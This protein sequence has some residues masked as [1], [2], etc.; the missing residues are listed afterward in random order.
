MIFVPQKRKCL[1][2]SG[3]IEVA[4]KLRA[5]KLSS[6]AGTFETGTDSP[7][8]IRFGHFTGFLQLTG[9]H[10]LIH[11]AVTSKENTI[12]RK[13]CQSGICD[14]IDIARNKFTRRYISP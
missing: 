3:A 5:A 14:F 7:V 6:L 8:G 1:A 12:T 10:A 11:Y 9:Q 2:S 13:L 4:A